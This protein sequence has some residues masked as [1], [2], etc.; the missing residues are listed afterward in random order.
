VVAVSCKTPVVTLLPAVVIATPGI[1]HGSNFAIILGMKSRQ[2][3]DIFAE[4][5]CKFLVNLPSG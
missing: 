3:D 5:L 4:I 1:A 2:Q